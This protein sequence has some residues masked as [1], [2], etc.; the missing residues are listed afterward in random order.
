MLVICFILIIILFKN[1]WFINE[2][3]KNGS[4]EFSHTKITEVINTYYLSSVDN[5]NEDIVVVNHK[6]L[7]EKPNVIE[8]NVTLKENFNTL[9]K[10]MNQLHELYFSVLF[11][12][13]ITFSVFPGLLFNLE[14]L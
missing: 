14:M 9:K 3:S 7:D 2:I 13:I 11:I 10:L 6:L 12:F 5:T 4:N 8:K 1:P